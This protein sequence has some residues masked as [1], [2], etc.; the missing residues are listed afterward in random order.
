MRLT[1]CKYIGGLFAF[2]KTKNSPGIQPGEA[3]HV[4]IP[5]GLFDFR[6]NRKQEEFNIMNVARGPPV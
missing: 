5:A 4:E 6:E 3:S 1:I 2:F